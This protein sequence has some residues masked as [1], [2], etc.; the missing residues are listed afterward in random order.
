MFKSWFLGPLIKSTSGIIIHKIM[1]GDYELWRLDG[2]GL[3]Y[4]FYSL[5]GG[6]AGDKKKTLEEL[7]SLLDLSFSS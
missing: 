1:I 7:F 4:Q 3:K 2:C 5:L 6:G